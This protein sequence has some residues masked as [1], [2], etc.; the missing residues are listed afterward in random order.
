MNS[1]WQ[2][3]EKYSLH[4][5]HTMAGLVALMKEDNLDPATVLEII[6]K[7]ITRRNAQ[8]ADRRYTTGGTTVRYRY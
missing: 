7:E 8:N 3:L 4:T 2:I 5:L 6:N 1:V